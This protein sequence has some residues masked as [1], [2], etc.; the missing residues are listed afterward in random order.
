MQTQHHYHY[1][2]KTL[3]QETP[4]EHPGN[5]GNRISIQEAPQGCD[6]VCGLRA[7]CRAQIWQRQRQG[8]A[9]RTLPNRG[10]L[11]I[12]CGFPQ[13]NNC[14]D[15]SVTCN[16]CNVTCWDE[17]P[18]GP[19]TWMQGCIV[20]ATDRSSNSSPGKHGRSDPGNP[21]KANKKTIN[22]LVQETLKKETKQLS[23]EPWK[24]KKNNPT[25]NWSSLEKKN[26]H[27]P[28]SLQAAPAKQIKNHRE[29]I[30]PGTLKKRIQGTGNPGEASK[31]SSP[32][33]R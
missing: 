18:K 27:K 5:P 6:V 21:G 24:D 13:N 11:A 16:D 19:A 12:Y 26:Q 28:T 4:K 8:L 15:C 1:H 25:L 29:R 31:H 30:D 17:G 20:E 3:I 23:L 9:R 33:N 10:Q 2:I 7:P 32:G 22:A 14:N